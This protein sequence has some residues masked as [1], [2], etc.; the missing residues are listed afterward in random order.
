M[1]TENKDRG[2]G[3]KDYQAANRES[4][5][6]RDLRDMHLLLVTKHACASTI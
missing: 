2:A 5:L 1:L 3:W 4:S 6:S